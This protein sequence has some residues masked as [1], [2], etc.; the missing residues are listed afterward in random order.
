MTKH[1]TLYYEKGRNGY[2]PTTTLDEDLN[3]YDDRVPEYYKGI[4]SMILL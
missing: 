2:T 4:A 1:N 3:I